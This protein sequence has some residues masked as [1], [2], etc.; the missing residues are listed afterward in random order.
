MF[1]D[2]KFS[3]I[4]IKDVIKGPFRNEDE[5]LAQLKRN[6]A[7]WTNIWSELCFVENSSATPPP[8]KL[9][10][11]WLEEASIWSL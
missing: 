9:S 1:S 2:F 11:T 7:F 3:V 8:E 10:I 5:V 6:N 4:K